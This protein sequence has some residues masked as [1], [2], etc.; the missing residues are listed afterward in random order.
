MME[1]EVERKNCKEW[2]K[3]LKEKNNLVEWEKR[4]CQ[5]VDLLKGREGIPSSLRS[6]FRKELI[7]ME[8]LP[9]NRS[10]AKRLAPPPQVIHQSDVEEDDENVNQLDECSYLYR[11]MQEL[12]S[13]PARYPSFTISRFL[14]A[15]VTCYPSLILQLR[16]PSTELGKDERVTV[17]ISKV[18]NF[19]QDGR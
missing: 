5:E 2:K 18:A 13:M 19:V 15:H 7:K 16:D 8:Q 11:L 1:R 4:S 9:D 12:E 3:N 10:E 17:L 14:S 6:F